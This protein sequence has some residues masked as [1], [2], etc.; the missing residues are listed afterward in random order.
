MP[1][2][3]SCFLTICQV[4][5]GEQPFRGIRPSEI[6]YW[7]STGFRPDKPENAEAIGI[8]EPL[9]NLIQ[10]CW[11]G[12][13]SQRPQI[14]EVVEGVANVADKWRVLTPPNVTEHREDSVEE[15]SDELVHGEFSL[16][17]IVPPVFRSSV[18]S[19]Y[20]SLMR[21]RMRTCQLSPNISRISTG[22]GRKFAP[23]PLPVRLNPLEPWPRF[24]HQRMAEHSS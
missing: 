12:D 23:Q 14:Q 15:E 18:Q 9:W 13:R 7:V 21:V 19:E 1:S 6:A 24:C 10:K 20:S 8:S 4:L 17:P 11:D 2:K 3:S 16:F 5:T 22:S